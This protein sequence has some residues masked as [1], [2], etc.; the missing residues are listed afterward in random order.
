M[1]ATDASIKAASLGSQRF[2]AIE[3][4]LF[5][6]LIFS[7]YFLVH[8]PAPLI[9]G[10]PGCVIYDSIYGTLPEVSKIPPQ[11]HQTKLKS[12]PELFK[13]RRLRK[14]VFAMPS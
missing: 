6:F 12:T 11:V 1:F 2:T 14:I 5:Q 13:S 7:D 9:K 3:K 4:K 8:P 10:E